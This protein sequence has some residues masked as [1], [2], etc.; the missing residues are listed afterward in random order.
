MPHLKFMISKTILQ[1]EF[2]KSIHIVYLLLIVDKKIVNNKKNSRLYKEIV[3]RYLEGYQT[4]GT[5]SITI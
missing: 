4:P 1:Y 2:C 3:P 5:R